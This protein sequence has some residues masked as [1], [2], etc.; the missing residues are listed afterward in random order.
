MTNTELIKRLRLG[1]TYNP[2]TGDL[3]D[4]TCIMD[5][6]ADALEAAQQFDGHAEFMQSAAMENEYFPVGYR[7]G[8]KAGFLNAKTLYTHPSLTN[9]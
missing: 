2:A 9:C 8:Y 6:A 3:Q 5:E 1:Q 4:M 7:A